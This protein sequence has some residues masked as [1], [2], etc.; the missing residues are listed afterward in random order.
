MQNISLTVEQ[1]KM[2]R[3]DVPGRKNIVDRLFSEKMGRKTTLYGSS[4]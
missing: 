2:K 4:T 3:K 1:E